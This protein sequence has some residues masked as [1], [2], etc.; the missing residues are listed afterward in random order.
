MRGSAS[1]L[2]RLRHFML[3]ALNFC[4]IDDAIVV[5]DALADKYRLLTGEGARRFVRMAEGQASRG[6]TEWLARQGMSGPVYDA[7]PAFIAPVTSAADDAMAAAPL[8]LATRAAWHQARF[9]RKLRRQPLHRLLASLASKPPDDG[10]RLNASMIVAAFERSRRYLS[11]EDKCLPR[12]LAMAYMLKRTGIRT[13]LIFGVTLP[14][15]AHCWVQQ[16]D[17]VL[18]DRLD[19]VRPFQPIMIV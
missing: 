17:V 19:R 5:L 13:Q 18:S 14:F 15:S 2:T 16:G 6:D 12:A 8:S 10:P 1:H 3:H 11:A 9:D 4:R 7:L